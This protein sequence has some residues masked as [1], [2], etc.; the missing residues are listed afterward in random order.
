MRSECA[1]RRSVG[2]ALARCY[3]ASLVVRAL[4]LPI[5]DGLEHLGFRCTGCGNCCRDLRVTV[6]HLD[7]ARLQVATGEAAAAL[8]DWLAPDDVDMTGEPE[9]FVE[10]NVGRRLMVLAQTAGACRWLDESFRCRVYAARPSDC[11]TYPFSI[12]PRADG[13]TATLSL[14]TFTS[15]EPKA[16]GAIDVGADAQPSARVLT[17]GDDD[18]WRELTRYQELVARWNRLARHR[19]RLGHRARAAAEFF[20]FLGL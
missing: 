13:T 2:K 11:R 19:R 1:S 3:G 12:E 6:T 14:L 4:S 20:E 17:Q 9:S 15:C 7:V 8:V 5:V 18:R 16:D 10:L